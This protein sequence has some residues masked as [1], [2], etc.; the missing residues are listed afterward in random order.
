M[1]GWR[2]YARFRLL[3][4][5]FRKADWGRKAGLTKMGKFRMLDMARV[6]SMYCVRRMLCRTAPAKK[7]IKLSTDLEM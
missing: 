4:C 2:I 3:V 7:D 5:L 6:R 1:K